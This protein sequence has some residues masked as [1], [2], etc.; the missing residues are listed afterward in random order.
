MHSFKLFDYNC[1]SRPSHYLPLEPSVAPFDPSL[2]LK[3]QMNRKKVYPSS[4]LWFLKGDVFGWAQWLTRQMFF[5][6]CLRPSFCEKHVF[7]D[8]LGSISDPS[9]IPHAAHFRLRVPQFRF[10]DPWTKKRQKGPVTHCKWS[11]NVHLL[12]DNS[13]TLFDSRRDMI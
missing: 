8:H 6:C 5:K 13:D 12:D 10:R 11:A 1:I 9:R 3:V 7:P 4:I 2:G